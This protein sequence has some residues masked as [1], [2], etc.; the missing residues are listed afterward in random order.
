[1]KTKITVI[2]DAL[3][4]FD[5]SAV[6]VTCTCMCIIVCAWMILYLGS[7]SCRHG[8]S[9][10]QTGLDEERKCMFTQGSAKYSTAVMQTSRK[11]ARQDSFNFYFRNTEKQSYKIQYN[12]LLV[13]LSLALGAVSSHRNSGHFCWGKAALWYVFNYLIYLDIFNVVG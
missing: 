5:E 3:F 11:P 8:D 12:G 7:V 9:A 2:I 1:M 10:N 6:T 4:V 13:T